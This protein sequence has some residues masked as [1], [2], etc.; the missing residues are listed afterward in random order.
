[1]FPEIYPNGQATGYYGELTE[2]AVKK[3]Q[4]KTGLAQTGEVDD[5]TND[6]LNRLLVAGEKKKPP[7]ITSVTPDSG[8]EGIMVTLSGRGFTDDNNAIMMRGKIVA[9]GLASYDNNTQIDFVLNGDAPCTP[10][11]K[12]PCPIKVVN[13]NGISNAKPFKPEP[14]PLPEPPSPPPPPPPSDTGAP[15]RSNGLPLGELAHGTKSANLS[16]TTDE[17]ATCRYATAA[18]M[19]YASMT[20]TFS[21]TGSMTH[22]SALTSLQDGVSYN[23]YVRCTDTAGNANTDDYTIAFSVATPPKPVITTLSPT[24]GI[25]GTQ[26][27][28]TGSGFTA[29]GNTVSFAGVDAATNLASADGKTL[30]FTT[31]T[32]APC[33]IG[34]T[35]TVSVRNVNGTSNESAFLR[36][37]AVSP[38]TVVFPNGGENLVQGVDF[39]LSW[40]GGTDRVDVVLVEE[41]ATSGADP[42]AFI[43]GWIANALSP[44]STVDWN[45]KTVCSQDNTVCTDIA[46]GKYKLMA[47]SEDEIGAMTIWDDFTNLPGNWDLSASA[48]TVSPSAT[49]T[50]VVPNGKEVGSQNSAFIICWAAVDLKSKA[51]KIDLLKNGTLY[52]TLN[53]YYPQ[54]Y[55][56]GAF[57]TQW[58]IPGDIPE[59]A[60]YQVKVS[61]VA[62]P[63]QNDTSDKPFSVV[64]RPSSINVYQ[65]YSYN[66]WYSGFDG[67][68][69]WYSNKVPSKAVT[70]NLWKGGFFYRTLASNVPQTYYTGGTTY[71]TGQFWQKVN[72]PADLPTSKDYTVE[73][74]DTGD[75]TLRGF[76]APFAIVQYPSYLTV[77]GK[78]FDY[79]TKVP[80]A[81]ATIYTGDG[82]YWY[83][84]YTNTNGELNITAT[85]SDILLSRSHNFWTYPANYN[86]GSFAI[87]SSPYGLYAYGSLFPFVGKS[88]LYFPVTGSEVNFGELPFWP[89]VHWSYTVSDVPTKVS[90]NYRHPET[91]QTSYNVWSS[92]YERFYYT[93]SLW[94]AIPRALDVWARIEDKPG[95]VYYSPF[96][97]LPAT[98]VAPPQTISLFNQTPVWEPYYIGASAYYYPYLF[99]VGTPLAGSAYAYGGIAPYTWSVLAGAL[100]P[101]V[102]LSSSGAISGAPTTAGVYDATLRVQDANK[103]NGVVPLLRF[104]VR[105]ET[106]AQVPTIKVGYPQARNELYP[107]GTYHIEWESFGGIKS[108]GVELWKAGAVVRKISDV[109]QSSESGR[110]HLSWKVPSD[111]AGGTDYYIRVSDNANPATYGESDPFIILSLTQGFYWS[112]WRGVYSPYLWFPYAT[113]TNPTDASYRLY[114]QK[115]GDAAPTLLATFTVPNCNQYQTSGTW[116]L[117]VW[118][119]QGYSKP[120]WSIHHTAAAPASEF[121]AGDYTYEL[122]A[123]DGAGAEKSVIV[124]KTRV[125]ENVH[126][127]SPL[128]V[129]SPL[130]TPTPTFRWTLP[131]DWPAGVEKTYQLSVYGPC[132]YT[133]TY[134]SGETYTYNYVCRIYYSYGVNAPGDTEGFRK[135]DGPALDPTKKYEVIVEYQRTLFD[136]PTAAYLTNI[137]MSATS[138]TFW[139]GQ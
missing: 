108:V 45:V 37:Q 48:F 53:S 61:D 115:T 40:T 74:V 93:R 103:V 132:S 55:E 69:S 17:N 119:W 27:T 79:V 125:L 100:P 135:Y 111:L 96:L 66:I 87:Y 13:A 121:P 95:N 3:F 67:P 26:V 105:T 30:V 36:T 28:I 43:V 33:A 9:T 91:G 130:S 14:A 110:F 8:S 22:T 134:P 60:D 75:P 89:F 102:T 126:L 34:A 113:S 21:S 129:D 5:K 116:A 81:G 25:L 64:A 52:R 23:Y 12:K 46:P 107:G 65:P 58:V 99:K 41:G 59:G 139:V 122:K 78:M 92:P 97:H 137:A 11:G 127:V 63:E 57:I 2:K 19:A 24:K 138:T 35:C 124:T 73:V 54:Y 133:Y 83:S 120:V 18:G 10:G 117:S 7:K 39:T 50:V 112:S 32:L 76:S 88:Y 72:I 77:K 31:P 70:I 86:Y 62:I 101:G 1:M 106:G 84:H 42:G 47:L 20:L 80:L 44:N 56:T 98:P 104:D 94:N 109:T 114:R 136:A 6:L 131:K 38:V 118:C 49:L 68:V 4:E 51:V 82:T 128:S 16:I 29:T 15:I 90:I 71:E 123:V 85:T